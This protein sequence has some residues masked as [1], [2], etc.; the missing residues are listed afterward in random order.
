M[1]GI[2]VTTSYI[3]HQ[4]YEEVRTDQHP[5]VFICGRV[6]RSSGQCG[7]RVPVEDNANAQTRLL[8]FIGRIRGGRDHGRPGRIPP[9]GVG[10]GRLGRMPLGRLTPG[11]GSPLPGALGVGFGV[12]GAGTDADGVDGAGAGVGPGAAWVPDRAWVNVRRT[13]AS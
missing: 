9:E 5:I 4:A 6:M 13:S 12:D 7:P 3:H 10:S 1:F 8:A 2:L 11:T